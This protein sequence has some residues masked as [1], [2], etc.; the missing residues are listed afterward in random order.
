MAVIKNES[1]ELS[2]SGYK[3]AAKVANKLHQSLSDAYRTYSKSAQKEVGFNSFY[4]DAMSAINRAKNELA[5]YHKWKHILTNIALAVAGL[6]VGY[7]VAITA[8][9]LINGH[10]TFFRPKPLALEKIIE[11]AIPSRG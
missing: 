5:T 1:V 8:N 10:L 11:A 9:K 2:Q 6:G 4:E 3:T 7:L